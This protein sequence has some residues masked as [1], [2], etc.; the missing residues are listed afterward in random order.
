MRNWPS[1][2][3]FLA[4]HGVVDGGHQGAA[5]RINQCADAHH[6]PKQ[7]RRQ[8][9]DYQSQHGFPWPS[10]PHGQRRA[11]NRRNGRRHQRIKNQHQAERDGGAHPRRHHLPAE[12]RRDHG[13]PFPGERR[14]AHDDH[15]MSQR[16]NA[17]CAGNAPESGRRETGSDVI[18]CRQEA[19]RQCHRR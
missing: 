2:V 15:K 12:E 3:V 14:S 10:L 13:T 17:S 19:C 9:T 8:E 18:H 7:Q 1:G 6:P 5:L 4:A 16:A 11:D